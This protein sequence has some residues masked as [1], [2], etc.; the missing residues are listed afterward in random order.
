MTV[1][2]KKHLGQHF[3]TDET[4]A[5]KIA[6]SLSENG[7][8]E[9]LE[10]GPGMG[11]LTKY[12]LQKK[13]KITVFEIDRESVEYL[14]ETF[15]KEHFQLNTSKEKFEII[16]GDFLKKNLHEIFKGQQVAIIGNFPYNISSQILFKA[17]EN[18]VIIPE[19]SGMFQ[20][21]VALRIA[22]K[23]G[24]KTYGILSVLSQAFYDVEYLFTVPPT[25]FNPPPKV[26]SG[27]IRLVR[28]ENFTL[29]VDEKL[30]F[31]VVKTAF[32]QRRKMLRSSLKSF[33]I[34]D[35]LKEDPIF[36]KRPEQLSVQEFIFLTQKIANND[37]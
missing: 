20:K 26:D 14:K 17:I 1:K 5:Q 22:E 23:E 12:L 9:V 18:R 8:N 7:Y 11:V 37:L 27:V 30:F 36:A 15:P 3:L 24:S 34:S 33:N 10:I 29:P 32:N 31:S 6:D 16:E 35:S 4:I 25:V 19:F 13:S 21:E 28:K 2:A